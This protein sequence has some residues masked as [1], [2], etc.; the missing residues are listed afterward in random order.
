MI[1]SHIL[2]GDECFFLRL[3]RELGHAETSL[4]LVCIKEGLLTWKSVLG[5]KSCRFYELVRVRKGDVDDLAILFT[6]SSSF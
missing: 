2:L 5:S 1:G 6:N 3:L 4:L